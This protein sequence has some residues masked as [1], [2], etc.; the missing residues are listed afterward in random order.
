MRMRNVIGKLALA[1]VV[2][3]GALGAVGLTAR[4]DGGSSPMETSDGRYQPYVGDR[5]ALYF[6]DS[7]VEVWGIDNDLTG[8]YL[9]TFSNAE[10]ASGKVVTHVS[11]QGAITLTMISPAETHLGYVTDESSDLVQ[12]TDKAGEYSISWKGGNYGADGSAAF[13]KYF[14]GT[15]VE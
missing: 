10:L 2:M 13:T 9:T 5:V 6:T 3:F 1:V 8:H 12:I 15:F 11:F 7:G 14:E 4:A